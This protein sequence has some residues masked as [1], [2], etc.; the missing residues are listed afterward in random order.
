LRGPDLEEWEE[1]E[2]FGVETLDVLWGELVR[3]SPESPEP[4]G[5]KGKVVCL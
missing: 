5:T 3:A 4:D 2:V 1:E